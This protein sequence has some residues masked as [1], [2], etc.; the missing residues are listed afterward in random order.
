MS[1]E[2]II[3]RSIYASELRDRLWLDGVVDADDLP[4]ASQINKRMRRD[5]VMSKKKLSVIPSE[6]N[7][8]EQIARQDEYLNVIST[9]KPHQIH[10]F[11]EASVIKT[12][13]N[14][15]YGNATFGEKAIEFQRYASNANF[16]VNLLHSLFGVD[17][18]NIL[19]GPSNGFELLHFFEDAVEIQRPDGS[20]LLERGDCV[21]MDNCGFHHGLFVEPV[22]RELLNDYGVQL[23]YQ[24]PYCP[25][26]NTCEYCFHQLKEFL[27]RCHILAME[28]TK[29]AISEGVSS[30]TTTN[31]HNYFRNCGYI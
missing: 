18:Y 21:V 31:S 30:I 22:L 2:K 23:I 6:S 29:I 24:P 11:D 14:R 4:S 25:H 27:R 28:E 13:G 20:V 19:D 12:T 26:L 3:K 17:Y 10:F 7:T 15:S 8:P 9:F 1:V 16:T 5:L